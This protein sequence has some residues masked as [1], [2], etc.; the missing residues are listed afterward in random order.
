MNTLQTQ[1]EKF[2]HQ[3]QPFDSSMD[4]SLLTKEQKVQQ[5][6]QKIIDL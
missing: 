5:P 3:Q 1:L 4:E 6:I 2:G